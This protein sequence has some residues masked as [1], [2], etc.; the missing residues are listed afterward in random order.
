MDA[1][2]SFCCSRGLQLLYAGGMLAAH[3]LYAESVFSLLPKLTEVPAYHEC[4]PVMLLVPSP[5][6]LLQKVTGHVA[7]GQA[8]PQL[9]W[10]LAATLQPAAA[11]LATSR[12]RTC[13]A[14]W[15]YSAAAL[16]LTAMHAGERGQLGPST[17]ALA[18][19]EHRALL[20]P[21]LH[22]KL[23][24]ML[25]AC[26]CVA[27]FDHHCTWINNCVGQGNMRWFLAF[28]ASHCLLAAYGERSPACGLSWLE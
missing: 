28:L 12:L 7:G 23:P 10:R 15:R 6:A 25:L 17:A 24:D 2:S 3:L 26:R 13:P 5:A 9:S 18:T 1:L 14:P 27:R 11:T 4:A 20:L 16:G 8:M 21:L 19:G 22:V